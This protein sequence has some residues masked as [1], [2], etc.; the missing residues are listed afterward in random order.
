M[1]RCCSLT[2]NDDCGIVIGTC[3]SCQPTFCHGVLPHY[4]RMLK[5]RNILPRPRGNGEEWSLRNSYL[6]FARTRKFRSL[7]KAT[8]AK[9]I[10]NARS[11]RYIIP[12]LARNLRTGATGAFPSRDRLVEEGPVGKGCQPDRSCSG[13]GPSLVAHENCQS[14]NLAF[15]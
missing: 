15:G 12:S 4:M 6:C 7:E 5:H 13:C 10:K 2:T 14:D 3:S 1:P 8:S 11:I 9:M